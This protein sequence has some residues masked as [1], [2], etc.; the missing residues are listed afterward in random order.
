MSWTPRPPIWLKS[1]CGELANQALRNAKISATCSPL[2]PSKFAG[3][4]VVGLPGSPQVRPRWN[5]PV[6][7]VSVPRVQAVPT[8]QAPTPGFSRVQSSASVRKVSRLF[9]NPATY[10]RV[11]SLDSPVPYSPPLEAAFLPSVDMVVAA[12]KKLV[13]Y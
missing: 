9:P 2:R 7:A 5:V 10:V 1:A 4:Q 8:Q 12:A 6:Q 3:Q 13:E 11:A